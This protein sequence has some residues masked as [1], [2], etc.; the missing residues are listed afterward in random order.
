MCIRDR[1]RLEHIAVNCRLFRCFLFFIFSDRSGCL[2]FGCSFVLTCFRLPCWSRGSYFS[3]VFV[4]YL[5]L[6]FCSVDLFIEVQ[7]GWYGKDE[8][9]SV[10]TGSR[11][12]LMCECNN[13]NKIIILIII[14]PKYGSTTAKNYLKSGRMF[15][16]NIIAHLAWHFG[17]RGVARFEIS[18]E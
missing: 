4:T 8:P 3:H 13:N 9:T 18:S 2:W 5:F 15:K 17:E 12:G 11:D 10:T 6:F 7:Q 1:S 16:E 14:K